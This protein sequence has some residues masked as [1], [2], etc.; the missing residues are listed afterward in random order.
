[1]KRTILFVGL[2]A[3]MFQ[4]SC[5]SHKEHHEEET[6][7]LVTTPLRADTAIATDYVCQIHSI[8]HIELRALERGYLENIYVDEGQ[9][10]KQG[11]LLFRIMPRIYEAEQ[12][13]AQAE[14]DFAEIEFKTTK[15][16]AD[17]N[18]V[19]PNELAMAQAKLDK[20]KAELALADV[21]LSFTEIRAPF[22]GIY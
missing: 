4:T 3:I 11:E 14:A 5:T 21:H 13:R 6:K 2:F 9:F 20:A 19:A 22:D 12:K 1:M 10:V 15:S 7:F 8:Q 16:L 17:S 18:V